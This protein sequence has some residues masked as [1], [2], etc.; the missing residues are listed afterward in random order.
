M[1]PYDPQKHHRCS[2][3]L[4]GYDYTQPGAYF[5]TLVAWGRACLF[6]EI[7]GETM[8]L[9]PVGEVVQHAWLRLPSFF[10]IRLDAY[11]VMPN[12][13][14]GIICMGEAS[15]ERALPGMKNSPG[16]CFAPTTEGALPGMKIVPA[17]ASPQPPKGTEPGSLGA[18]IQNFK[19]TST[20]SVNQIN[21]SPGIPLWQRN[22][23]ERVIRDEA[24]LGRIIAYI[25]ANP[26]H[27]REDTELL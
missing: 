25:Q 14:H 17:D 19:S 3:R 8:R 2:I 18:I 10:P 13:F 7:D 22:Y 26:A 4:K 16:R 27:W 6:G 1:T 12:H 24:E 21:A 9:N 15:A 11:V 20:R 5:V 23:F